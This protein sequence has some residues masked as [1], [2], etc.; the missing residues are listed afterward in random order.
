MASGGGTRLEESG[1]PRRVRIIRGEGM[2]VATADGCYPDEYGR[3]EIKAGITWV[4][5]DHPLAKLRPRRSGWLGVVMWLRP[6][7][8][9]PICWSHG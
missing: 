9:G 4:A 2:L 3:H 1:G 5:P 8:T 6:M 7:S